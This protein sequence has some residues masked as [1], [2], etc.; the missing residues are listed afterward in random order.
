MNSRSPH[1]KTAAIIPLDPRLPR[2]KA[3]RTPADP[4]GSVILFPQHSPPPMAVQ[5]SQMPHAN[6]RGFKRVRNFLVHLIARIDA[7]DFPPS[8]CG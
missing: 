5:A 3:R 8:C 2:S 4:A 1:L 6:S 7:G